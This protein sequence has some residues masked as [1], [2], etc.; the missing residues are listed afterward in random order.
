MLL[1]TRGLSLSVALGTQVPAAAG[2]RPRNTPPQGGDDDGI[3]CREA[4]N[5]PAFL[6]CPAAGSNPASPTRVDS[7]WVDPPHPVSPSQP[8][9]HISLHRA[10]GRARPQKPSASRTRLPGVAAPGRLSPRRGPPGA[11]PGRTAPL[12][13]SPSAGGT[14][15]HGPSVEAERLFRGLRSGLPAGINEK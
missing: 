1:G 6:T 4:L 5:P 2:R 15:R 11:P 9:T 14:Q 10:G 12:P 3:T 7:R 13:W 8:K